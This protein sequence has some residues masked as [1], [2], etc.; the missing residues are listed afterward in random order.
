MT[1]LLYLSVELRRSAIT[2]P[3]RVSVLHFVPVFVEVK[4]FLMAQ[5]KAAGTPLG[6]YWAFMKAL[7]HFCTELGLSAWAAF[8]L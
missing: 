6:L 4:G 7:Q 5:M 3:G 1:D 8:I 2:K